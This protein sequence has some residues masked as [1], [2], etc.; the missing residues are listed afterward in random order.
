MKKGQFRPLILLLI[1][2]MGHHMFGQMVFQTKSMLLELSA[3]GEIR[4]MVDLKTGT[5]YKPDDQSAPILQI[6]VGERWESP[7]TCSYLPAS[8]D[9]LGGFLLLDFPRNK[10]KVR[11]EIGKQDDYLKL[12]LVRIDSLD[13]ISTIVWGPIP[14][15][16]QETVAEIIGV[17]KNAEFAIGIQV[18]NVKTLG[19]YPLNKEGSDPSRSNTAK[20]MEWGS[21]L[22]AFSINRSK[23]RTVDG[24]WGQYPNMPVIPIQN[25][26]VLG[27]SIAI[28]GCNPDQIL[29]HISTI[30]LT[31]H[32]PHPLIDGVWSKVSPETG[33]SYLI[34]DYSES[35]I[36]ELLDYTKQANLM[37]LYHMNAWTSW[38]H[39]EL[40]SSFFPNGISGIK[41]CVEKA[42]AMGIRLGAHTL[43]D[44]IN[45]NDS[46]ITPIPDDRLAYTGFVSLDHAASQDDTLLILDSPEYV[47]NSK[48]NWLR[49]IRID[50][51]LIQYD[52]VSKTTPY[53]L[54]GCKRGAFHT[55]PAPHKEGAEV[56]KLL[57]H[58]YLVFFPNL[59]L[60]KEIAKNLAIRF[61]E[62]GLEQMDF[63][64]H[65]GCLS[66]GQG[67]YALELFAKTFY[68]N[69][70][71]P[72]L[73]G[74][75][76]SEPFYWHINTYCNWGEP[77][78][79]GFTESMQQYR[80]DNQGL[81][82][83]N[84][85]PN[86]LGWYLLTDSTTLPEMEWMLARSAGYN[87]G[88][89]MATSLT[90]LQKNPNTNKLLN[91][92]REWEYCRHQGIFDVEIRAQ[93]K[94]PKN[95]FHL[96]KKSSKKWLLFPMKRVEGRSG[97]VNYK[98][99]KP[100]L[101]RAH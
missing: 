100:I 33:R 87:A 12:E 4:K 23:P 18:L 88:F 62:T 37:T 83:R 24:W 97:Q 25:E 15:S 5:N 89:A 21:V 45:I 66:S 46:Y 20:Q 86:M 53:Q 69:L 26:T 13:K 56:Y 99:G 55:N 77:W 29:Q 78:N 50:N 34:A 82:E 51:E 76:N 9:P 59:E 84:L 40:D 8:E 52:S 68:D 7:S 61:N 10:V 65:E 31:E 98:Q 28:F 30:E 73:N 72:V 81:L 32:L 75:S 58:P 90:A 14:T 41:K 54:M 17:V 42:K 80:L 91:A 16:I 57:D 27:S 22:Q 101:I 70:D 2:F 35:T 38:G 67:D 74:T 95:E 43:T 36:D 1:L 79:G 3:Q 39:Y 60:Q 71:H 48:A 6:K 64:G 44:F 85:L 49:T 96:V 94:N 93:L 63:D 19:G 11:I 47:N 92:I